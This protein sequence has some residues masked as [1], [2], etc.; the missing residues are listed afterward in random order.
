MGPLIIHAVLAIV[1]IRLGLYGVMAWQ[2][3]RLKHRV[4]SSVPVG[5]ERFLLFA[6]PV[7]AL[8]M[9]IMVVN[10]GLAVIGLL[11]NSMP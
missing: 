5:W 6:L 8:L 4:A 7:V 11:G 3:L 10:S 2:R 1:G 9:A